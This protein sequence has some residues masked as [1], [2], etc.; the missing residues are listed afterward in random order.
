[1]YAYA[2]VRTYVSPYVFDYS[3]T[4]QTTN[5]VLHRVKTQCSVGMKKYETHKFSI[6]LFSKH[7]A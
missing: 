5:C 4:S 3:G 7:A 2:I 1:M 6:N